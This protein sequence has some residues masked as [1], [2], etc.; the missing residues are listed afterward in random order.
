[1]TKKST[2]R[3]DKLVDA[4]AE[5]LKNK[6]EI[7]RSVRQ[8]QVQVTSDMDRIARDLQSVKDILAAVCFQ[9]DDLSLEISFDSV[10]SVPRESE[11][12]IT[13]DRE[14]QQYIF[15]LVVPQSSGGT[16]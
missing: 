14:R 3:I 15:K 7:Q 12:E 11:L 8:A 5:R 2:A 9:Q 6:P 10:E 4:Q 16:E 13:V 1:M